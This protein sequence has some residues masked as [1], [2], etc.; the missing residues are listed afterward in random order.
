MDKDLQEILGLIM[1]TDG[2]S[3]EDYRDV[4]DKIA[5]HESKGVADQKQYDGGPGRGLYQFEE[6]KDQG[7]IT[8]ARRAANVYRDNKKPVPVWL[9][10]ALKGDS[11]DASTL[12]PSQQDVLFLGNMKGH[13]K[14]S[15]K[16]VIDGDQKLVDFWA[17]NHW[18][19]EDKDRE[20][21]TK[22]FSGSMNAYSGSKT[23]KT[24]SEKQEPTWTNQQPNFQRADKL[25]MKP[26]P[27]FQRPTVEQ[28][29]TFS[30]PANFQQVQPN[31][32]NSIFAAGGMSQVQQQPNELNEF[33]EGGTHEQS[34]IRGIPM[35][36]NGKGGQNLVEEGETSKL[37][38]GNTYIFSHRNKIQ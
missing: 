32:M 10:K 18:A 11:I 5:Y 27:N 3:K 33:N 14:A 26:Q 17:N 28:D 30:N 24:V 9:Q 15:F 1:K 22:S 19:G 4:L 35:G 29:S 8:A 16:K 25:S 23:K 2:G 20:A 34:P 21:R 36:A 13:P 12:S 7:G 31:R 38:N 37:I 6:G